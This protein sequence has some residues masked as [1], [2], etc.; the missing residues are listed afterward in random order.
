MKLLIGAVVVLVAADHQLWRF[1]EAGPPPF[2]LIHRQ[3]QV[4]AVLF[5]GPFGQAHHPAE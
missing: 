4:L 5:D 2:Q 3:Q 1:T